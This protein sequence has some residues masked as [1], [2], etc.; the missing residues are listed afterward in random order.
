[1]QSRHSTATA[2]VSIKNAIYWMPADAEKWALMM[3]LLLYSGRFDDSLKRIIE[4]VY[5]LAPNAPNLQKLIAFDGLYWWSQSDADLRKLWLF[6]M[7][8]AL[9]YR[10]DEFL[11]AVVSQRKE[12][13]LC[14]YAGTALGLDKWCQWARYMRQEC[15]SNRLTADQRSG[16][17]QLG[18]AAPGSP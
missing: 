7:H 13:R 15:R 6:G 2:F 4:N 17:R 10:K 12:D 3:Q 5:R 8:N 18:F 1:M 14:Q 11:I 16:C 9:G